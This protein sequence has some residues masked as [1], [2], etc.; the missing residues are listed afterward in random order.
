MSKYQKLFETRWSDFDANN[1]MRHTVYN[2]CAAQLRLQLLQDF[3]LG[4]KELSKMG[5]GPIL[6][7]E[8]TRYLREVHIGDNIIVDVEIVSLTQDGRKW[9]MLHHIYKQSNGELAATVYVE[10]AWI[11]LQKRKTAPAPS[12]F[13]PA[14]LDPYKSEDFKFI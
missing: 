1:H 2:D 9:N 8:E 6:F 13:T 12:G 7:K 14:D 10:G 11:D 4:M 5:I 3:N